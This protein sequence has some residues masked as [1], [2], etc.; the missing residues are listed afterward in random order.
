MNTVKK[1]R[2]RHCCEKIAH[3]YENLLGF[4]KNF[5]IGAV[6]NCVNLVD[7]KN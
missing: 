1:E 5:E 3:F 2:E 7:L 4:E 6:Q